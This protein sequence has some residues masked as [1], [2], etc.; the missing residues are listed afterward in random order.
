MNTPMRNPVVVALRISRWSFTAP[1][2]SHST[3][4]SGPAFRAAVAARIQVARF[5]EDREFALI[6]AD[7]APAEGAVARLDPDE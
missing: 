1:F 2:Y 6:Q 3:G 4:F 5:L 7:F